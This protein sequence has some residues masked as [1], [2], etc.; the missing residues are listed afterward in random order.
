M[1]NRPPRQIPGPMRRRQNEILVLYFLSVRFLTFGVDTKD[2]EI[3]H[4]DSEHL[5]CP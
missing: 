5:T 3:R 1:L 2:S 4:Q